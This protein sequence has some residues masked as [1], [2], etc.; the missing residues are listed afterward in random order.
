MSTFG[1]LL[2]SYRE[3]K[4]ISQKELGERCVPSFSKIYIAKLETGSKKAPPKKT[5]LSLAQ[6]LSLAPVET[7][8]LWEASK[9]ERLSD[10]FLKASE[11]E[12]N[13]LLNYL[14]TN[15]SKD[16][17]RSLTTQLQQKVCVENK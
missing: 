3:E 12:V 2:K 10:A 14:M 8:K 1:L 11:P 5:V 7:Q 9:N 15:L 4:G 13:S 17:L 16:E 6:A